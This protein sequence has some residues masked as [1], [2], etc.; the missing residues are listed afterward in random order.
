MDRQAE[1]TIGVV[2]RTLNEAE[3][4]GTCLETLGRQ[5]SRFEL[6][7]LVVDS[8]STDATLEIARSC[9]ARILELPPGDFDYS[10]SL[11]DGI[12]QVRGDLVLILS[13]HA[14]P[15]DEHWVERMT[16]PFEDPRVAGVASRQLPWDDAPWREVLRLA[17]QFGADPP[18]LPRGEHGRAGVQQRRLLH[19]AQRVA[20]AAVP[21]SGGRG[22]R[23]GAAGG[24]GGLVRGLRARL[25]PSTTP[26]ARAPRAQAQRLIDISRV[27]RR[28]GG[29]AHAGAG[30][31]ARPPGSSTATRA[32]SSASTSRSRRKLA[33]LDRAGPRSSRT[34]SSTSRER[35]RRR[36]GGAPTP[37][38]GGRGAAAQRH[39]QALTLAQRVHDAARPG[40]A[41]RARAAAAA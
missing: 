33:H 27:D 26:I 13:A 15:V 11:N 29:G 12:E 38:S 16:A 28:R 7:V 24:G 1:T 32:R 39:A 8:G 5:R 18:R 2:I 22:P 10:K 30:R 35:E 20:R 17:R 25:P 21:A 36:S 14:V 37:D 9:G 23:V 41:A 40:S 19:P 4:I 34:T 3:L 31:S 6:D